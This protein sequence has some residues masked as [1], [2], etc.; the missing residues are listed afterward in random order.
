MLQTIT[1]GMKKK[2]TMLS[3][4]T[5]NWLFVCGL[6][7]CLGGVVVLSFMPLGSGKATS[8]N[9]ISVYLS[10]INENVLPS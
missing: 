2:D 10:L 5:I 9:N 7:F 1:I 3:I 4:G 6:A 8:L